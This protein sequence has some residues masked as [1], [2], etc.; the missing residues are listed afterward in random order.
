MPK[1]SPL[2]PSFSAG[3]FSPKLYGRVDSE[4]YK[5]GLATCLNYLPTTQG[6]IIRRPGF[7]YVADVK[8]PSQP[9]IFINFEFSATDAYILEFGH[10]YVRFFKNNARVTVAG[11]SYIGAGEWHEP[12]YFSVTPQGFLNDPTFSASRASSTVRRGELGFGGTQ[13]TDGAILELATLYKFSDIAGLKWSQTADTLYITHEKHMTHKLQRFGATDWTLRPCFLIDGPYLPFNSHLLTGDSANV[14][15]TPT[16]VDYKG[17]AGT[18]IKTGPK[19]TITNIVQLGYGVNSSYTIVALSTAATHSY[20][21]GQNL[22]FPDEGQLNTT[23]NYGTYAVNSIGP[24]DKALTIRYSTSSVMGTY[25]GSGVIYPALFDDNDSGRLVALAQSAK[26][27]W[28]FIGNAQTS[29]PHSV[30][31]VACQAQAANSASTTWQLG[32]FGYASS[33]PST[34]AFYQ[35][36]LFL[37]GGKYFPQMINGSVNGDYE[38]F[39][40]SNSSYVVADDSAL[41]FTLNSQQ[42]NAIKWLAPGDQGLLAGTLG[43]EW[44][45]AANNQNDAITPTNINASETGNFGSADA[46]ATKASSATLF[47]Q[48]GGKKVREMNFFYQVDTYRSTDITELSDHITGPGVTKFAVQ[49]EPIP[50]V[51]ALRSDGVLLSCNYS[52]DD[53]S[54]KVGWARHTLG[55][56][57]DSAG[58]APQVKTMAVIPDPTGS[59]DQVWVATKRFIN[60]TS[61]VQIEYSTPVFDDRSLLENA[62]QIDAGGSYNS[63]IVIS[64]ITTAGSSVVTATAHGLSN[65]DY[66]KINEVIGINSSITNADGVIFNSNLVNAHVFMV[67]SSAPNAFFLA[68]VNNGTSYINSASYSVYVSGGELRK[69]VSTITG[70]T[71]LKNETVQVLADGKAHREVV[72]NSGGILALDYPAAKVQIGLGYNS[73]GKTLRPDAGSGDGTSIGK[74]RRASKIAPMLHQSGSFKIGSD[75]NKLTPLE[76]SESD[77]GGADTAVGLFSGIKRDAVE[78]E[79]NFEGQVC[80]RQDG[81]LPGMVQAVTV[82]IEE[83]DV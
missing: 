18:Q 75:F 41:Q 23:F 27:I 35:D 69:L 62:F 70:L 53:Q 11:S 3:E 44:R 8:D 68:D 25:I 37:G 79:H 26:R 73:D 31:F 1:A 15:L 24:S 61:V 47:I 10:L 22:H 34:S 55:G 6:P 48:K 40:P 77:S 80:F 46:M 42:L 16:A 12:D 83:N 67:T 64:N 43:S 82:I 57:S 5:T 65:G 19:A 14:T 81:P 66:V 30:N 17:T 72:V 38:N 21:V 49:K 74:L 63:S 78:G 20:Y 39:A 50:C 45:I 13:Q 60:G 32:A 56:R 59:F 7:K 52:R 33:W 9:P 2:Q 51:W 54:L 58:T 29:S 36:R 76:F 4:R 28:G 71:W